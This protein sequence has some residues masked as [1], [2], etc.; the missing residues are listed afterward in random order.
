MGRKK[1][2]SDRG[3]DRRAIDAAVNIVEKY[4][5]ESLTVRAVGEK[6]GTSH[7]AL[8]R[9]FENKHALLA[10]I[11]EEGFRL[12]RD[13]L[14]ATLAVAPDGVTAFESTGR[15]YFEFSRTHRGYFL[16]MYSRELADRRTFPALATASAANLRLVLDSIGRGQRDGTIVRRNALGLAIAGWSL[17]H[18]LASLGIEGQLADAGMRIE[19]ALDTVLALLRDGLIPRK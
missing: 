12:M 5:M 2:D 11:A 8:Y 18:G 14:I 16:V 1:A 17:M 19:Q 13:R 3:L 4:G 6:I 9:H 7:V 15:V 10:A